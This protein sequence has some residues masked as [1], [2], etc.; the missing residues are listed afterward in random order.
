MNILTVNVRRGGS[1]H[2]EGNEWE[3]VPLC[4]EY[5]GDINRTRLRQCH[6]SCISHRH[7]QPYQDVVSS[8]KSH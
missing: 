2:V 8:L 1:S 7:V 6:H 3:Q 4:E 5:G